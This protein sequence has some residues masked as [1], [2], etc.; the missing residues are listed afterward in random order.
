MKTTLKNGGPSVFP[1]HHSSEGN[2]HTEP[3][4]WTTVDVWRRTKTEQQAN[5]FLVSQGRGRWWERDK[6]RPSLSPGAGGPCCLLLFHSSKCAFHQKISHSVSAGDIWCHQDGTLKHHRDPT[7][8]VQGWKCLWIKTVGLSGATT[9]HFLSLKGSHRNSDVPPGQSGRRTGSLCT[10]VHTLT[11]LPQSVL[12]LWR[13]T[14]RPQA[15]RGTAGVRGCVRAT[16]RRA[17]V[18]PDPHAAQTLHYAA[19]TPSR[20]TPPPTRSDLQSCGRCSWCGLGSLK[21]KINYLYKSLLSPH[22]FLSFIFLSQLCCSC[23]F[24]FSKNEHGASVRRDHE[25]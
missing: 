3:A 15:S 23:D 14:P 20:P 17:E 25:R 11:T 21:K 10:A 16:S 5:P 9:T 19:S 8:P 2:S 13:E 22:L 18:T 7:L 12:T 24:P 4:K 6:S 1:S